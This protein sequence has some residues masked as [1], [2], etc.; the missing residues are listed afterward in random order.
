MFG[1][2][3]SDISGRLIFVRRNLDGSIAKKKKNCHDG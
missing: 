1:S 2:S 3:A